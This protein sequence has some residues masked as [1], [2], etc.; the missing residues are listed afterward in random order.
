V[1][2]RKY[3]AI[4]IPTRCDT[5]W[6]TDIAFKNEAELYDKQRRD[7]PWI[8]HCNKCDA[9]VGTHPGTNMPLGYMANKDI[10]NKRGKLHRLLD[11]LWQAKIYDR[12]VLY[13]ALAHLLNM[14]PQECHVSTLRPK[15]LTIAINE[16]QVVYDSNKREI[17]KWEKK[18]RADAK[19]RA[20]KLARLDKRRNRKL[21]SKH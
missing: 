2:D 8:W 10:R 5:C 12:D 21:R 1:G 6:S 9:I 3:N 18:Q 15:Q 7:W 17:E 4:D 13:D 14:E 20:D 11:P 19:L 16:M